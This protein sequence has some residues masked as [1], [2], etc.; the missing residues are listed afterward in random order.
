MKHFRESILSTLVS[1]ILLI[2]PIYVTI[3]LLLKAMKSLGRAVRPLA[4]LLPESFPAEPVFSLLAVLMLC[5]LVG[6]VL[7]TPVGQAARIKIEES[8]LQKIPGYEAFRNMTQQLAGR[9]REG[10]W[11]P[12]LAEIEEALVPA[13]I[14]E[15][16][17]DRRFTVFVPSMVIQRHRN[18]RR[19]FEGNI[20]TPT[21]NRSQLA[22]R[23]R[24]KPQFSRGIAANLG[25]SFLQC[26]SAN[27]QQWAFFGAQQAL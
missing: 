14:V 11:Q 1:G 4:R 22:G 26:E 8:I 23:A 12:A 19:R 7:R 20:G 2:I 13:F 9:G 15:E 24:R 10:A 5:L 16:L 6:V 3:L 27:Q 25:I 21:V 18:P 17:D